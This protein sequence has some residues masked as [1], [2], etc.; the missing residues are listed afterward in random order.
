MKNLIDSKKILD[1]D[2]VFILIANLTTIFGVIF[3]NWSLFSILFLFWVESAIIGF[4]NVL[5]MLFSTAPIKEDSISW[6]TEDGNKISKKITFQLLKIFISIFFVIHYGIF[7]LG[8]LSFIFLVSFFPYIFTHNG[9]FPSNI[10]LSY[11]IF[12][13]VLLLFFSHGFSFIK[14]FIIK[15]EYL[16]TSIMALMTAPYGRIIL[17][18]TTLLFGGMFSMFLSIFMMSLNMETSLKI[19]TTSMVISLFIILKTFVD[20]NAHLREHSSPSSPS[21]L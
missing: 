11:E 18:H 20:I 10:G 16:K 7:M 14:N 17:M 1:S 4:Y 21:E 6:T 8:H 5:K 15:K 2:V 3:L 19:V 9:Y 13:P 12:I